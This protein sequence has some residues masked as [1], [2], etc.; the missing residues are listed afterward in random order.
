M[1]ARSKT[2]KP[3]KFF[4]EF[5]KSE[6][7]ILAKLGNYIESKTRTWEFATLSTLLKCFFLQQ[8]HKM[9]KISPCRNKLYLLWV[10]SLLKRLTFQKN[11]LTLN[12]LE[13]EGRR[14]GGQIDPPCGFPKNMFSKERVKP[15]VFGTFNIIISQ[16]FPG[17]FIEIP[18][19]LQKIWRYSPSILTI[20]IDFSDFW[21]FLVAKK[22]M[23][24]AYNRWYQHFFYFQATLNRLFNNCIKSYWI[25]SWNMKGVT[26]GGG[27][28]GASNWPPPQKKL[29][30]KSPALLGLMQIFA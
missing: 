12:R 19:V 1:A 5:F 3:R 14:G 27:G 21:N 30:S 7:S 28:G 15:W 8:N 10:V 26:R 20:F 23:T 16:I 22:L 29:P 4:P 6:F 18:Q 11:F 24:S 25:S 13:R 2:R 9:M 17:N